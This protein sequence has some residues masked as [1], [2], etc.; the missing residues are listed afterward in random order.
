MTLG[1]MGLLVVIFLGY[2]NFSFHTNDLY[3]QQPRPPRA[4][5]VPPQIDGS[6]VSCGVLWQTR[7]FCERNPDHEDIEIE[8]VNKQAH[9]TTC[10]EAL[11]AFSHCHRK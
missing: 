4:M 9:N 3:L 10:T 11:E 6:D 2:Q 7:N 1:L 8:D 5:H